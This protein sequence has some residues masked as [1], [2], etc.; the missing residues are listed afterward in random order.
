MMVARRIK[1][2][3][4]LALLSAAFASAESRIIVRIAPGGLPALKVVCTLLSCTV[5]ESIDGDLG[6]VY[7]V[8]SS[9]PGDSDSLLNALLSQT[10]VLAAEA[11]ALATTLQSGTQTPSSLTDQTPVTFFGSTVIRGYLDQPAT[12]LVSLQ[13]AQSSLH[14]TGSGTVAVID[15]GVDSNHPVLRT[16]L[17]PGYDFTRNTEGAD[18][19]LDVALGGIPA[20]DGASPFWTNPHSNAML[21]QSTAAVIDGN[22]QYSDYGHGTMV[23]GIIHLTAPTAQILPLKAFQADGKGYNSDILR[24]I[25]YAISRSASVINMS[26]NLAGDS[27]EIRN[28]LNL[29]SLLGIVNVAAAGNAGTSAPLYPASYPNVIGVASTSNSDQLSTFSSHGQTIWI[30]APGE[31]VVT[32]YP[33]GSYAAAWGTSFSAPFVSGTVALMHGL[34]LLSNQMQSAWATGHADHVPVDVVSG[35]LNVLKALNAV[36]TPLMD[37]QF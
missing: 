9:L 3:I 24:A 25:Y 37:G 26:F 18:E 11:D 35:R 32:T 15:T 36:S 17:L 28:A 8:T 1:Q 4:I 7:L 12:S 10:V 20:L 29:A 33:Y 23:A 34:P 2:L 19:T 6:Q 22:G 31:G 5:A 13:Q 27:P 16:V 30:A 14:M 21:T